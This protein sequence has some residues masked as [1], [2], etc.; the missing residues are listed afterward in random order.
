MYKNEK[1]KTYRLLQQCEVYLLHAFT[2]NHRVPEGVEVNEVFALATERHEDVLG[3][4]VGR[5]VGHHPHQLVHVAQQA[6]VDFR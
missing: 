4:G 3:G 5:P 2:P 1:K 6:V